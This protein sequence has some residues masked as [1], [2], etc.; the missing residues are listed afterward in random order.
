MKRLL[1]ISNSTQFGS[2]YLEH[3]QD[4]VRSFLGTDIEQ[5]LFV[6][7][8]LED[9]DGY[10]AKARS[11]FERIGYSLES[12]HTAPDPAAAVPDA[13]TVSEQAS[14]LGWGPCGSG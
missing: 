9:L 4:S 1:L 7:Y 5:I 6:P 8:A 11:G 2:G 13:L 14:P 10:A 12:I 3:C